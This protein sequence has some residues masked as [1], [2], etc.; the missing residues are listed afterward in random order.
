MRAVTL[1][2]RPRR[3]SGF[4]LSGAFAAAFALAALPVRAQTPTPTPTPAP[5]PLPGPVNTYVPATSTYFGVL[6]GGRYDAANMIVEPDSSIWSA[7]ANENVILHL[8]ANRLQSTRW[9]MTRDAAPSSLLKDPDGT[10]WVTE[11]GGFNVGKFNPATGELTEWADAGRRPTSLVRRPDGTFWLPETNGF[12]AQFDPKSGVFTYFKGDRVSSLS[13]P[14]LDP[15]GSLW[16]ADFISGT[17]LRFSPDGAR[18]TRWKLP[19]TRAYPSKIIRGFD[20]ALWISLY[21]TGQ[22]ARFDPALNEIRIYQLSAGSAPFDLHNYKNRILYSEQRSGVI[23]F[24]DPSRTKPV[25]VDTLASEELLTVTSTTTATPITTTLASKTDD[26]SGATPLGVTGTRALSGLAELPAGTGGVYAIAVDEQRA[27]IY[28]GTG[29][30]IGALT[31]PLAIG[32]DD[33]YFP[34]TASTGGAGGA[35]WRTQVV[36]WNRGTADSVAATKNL[37]FTERLFPSTWIAG[38]S[39]A[40]AVT[41]AAGGLSNQDDPIGQ[42]MDASGSF[43]ALRLAP[44]TSVSIGNDLFSW[45]RVY[46]TR[47]DG[48]T[49][50][51]AENGTK[52]ARAISAPESA[53][54]FAPPDVLSQ[55]T[56][57]G[58]FVLEASTGSVSIVDSDGIVRATFSYDWPGGYHIQGSTIFQ[59]LGISP[60]PSARVVFKVDSGKVFPFGT[61]IDRSTNDPIG[62]DVFPLKSQSTFQSMLGIARGAGPMGPGS[63]TDLQ[64][65]NP[66]SSDALVTLTFR[67]ARPV[68]GS[69]A[70]PGNPI[71]SVTV[72]A[73]KVLTLPDVLGAKLG[74]SGVT[75]TLD[76]TSDLPVYAFAR[77]IAPAAA[78]GT[79]GFGVPGQIRDVAVS[80]GTRG[81]FLADTDNGYALFQSDLHLTNLADSDSRLALKFT[82]A[83]G[84][85]AGSREITLGPRDV[86]SIEAVWY[87]STGFG[88]QVG[89]LDVVPADGS[90]P[91]FVTLLRQD[92]RTGDTDAILPI[93]IPR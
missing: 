37:S 14:W 42:E 7:S 80:S 88:T 83:D 36:S 40:A 86:R 11:L 59:A 93:V 87:S 77:V 27:R 72:N 44:D 33:Q 53:F 17:L 69:G 1:L 66:G 34:S 89:R 56:N 68:G 55:R 39:P 52:A 65:F 90:G 91:L 24:F 31:P 21:V 64:I 29:G 19:D 38:F 62:L 84:T 78:G 76:I 4:A 20:G 71:S 46:Y 54:L 45:A 82:N 63:R 12:L 28:F 23:G 48:G 16:S 22:L 2:K 32:P 8:A 15:D 13:Y 73:G 25:N 70:A 50:G 6:N 61:S 5:T 67:A 35:S 41:V 47:P 60:I 85:P 81:I 26:V 57:A 75:G 51:F 79:Y 18:I 9:T 49:Y 74:L 92:K 43:G 58:I 30:N 3:P 10:F